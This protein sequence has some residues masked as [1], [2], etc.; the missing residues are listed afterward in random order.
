ME[1]YTN[2]KQDEMEEYVDDKKVELEGRQDETIDYISQFKYAGTYQNDRQYKRFNT[3]KFRGNMYLALQD[4][5]GNDPTDIR[6]WVKIADNGDKVNWRGTWSAI[7]NYNQLDM[8]R[9]DGSVYICDIANYDKVPAINDNYWKLVIDNRDRV[10]SQHY[11]N[12][13]DINLH[14]THSM[15]RLP[16]AQLIGTNGYGKGGFGMFGVRNEYNIP[17]IVERTGT[18]IIKI[19]ATETLSGKPTITQVKQNEY[20]VKYPN[21]QKA[22]KLYL[23]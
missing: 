16:M 22:M 12:F 7:I 23:Y 11:Q 14:I 6:Y 19:F 13:K 15:D 1:D 17:T 2:L 3:V 9:Y 10:Q 20:E 8:V 18:N 4:V 21:E 5:K